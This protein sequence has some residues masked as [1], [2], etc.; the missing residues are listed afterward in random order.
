MTAP[1]NTTVLVVL[2]AA[3]V[4]CS[5]YAAGRL[6]QRLRMGRDRDEAYREGYDTAT[7]NVFS[8]AARIIVPRRSAAIR[9]S[10]KVPPQAPPPSSPRRRSRLASYRDNARTLPRTA[11]PRRPDPVES[12]EDTTL[13][14]PPPAIPDGDTTLLP[15]AA[16]IPDGAGPAAVGGPLSAGESASAGGSALAGAPGRHTVPD[17]L[18]QAATYRLQPDRVARAKV[19]GVAVDADSPVEETTRLPPVPRPRSS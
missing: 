10:A 13:L 15:P 14:P 7:R 9:G 8:L 2:L 16:V 6:H 4:A 18:V 17:E 1:G 19:Q 12:D 5:G 11:S 3:F